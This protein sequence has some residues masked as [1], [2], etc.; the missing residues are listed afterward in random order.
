MHT[1]CMQSFAISSNANLVKA[2]LITLADVSNFAEERK[3]V[4]PLTGECYRLILTVQVTVTK[5]ERTFSSLKIVK[6]PLSTTAADSKL[7]VTPPDILRERYYRLIKHRQ[8]SK[9]LDPP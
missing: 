7:R 1:F 9:G 2:E 3:S 8:I 4:F 5:E 6:N